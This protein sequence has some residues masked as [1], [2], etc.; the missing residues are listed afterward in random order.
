VAVNTIG[1]DVGLVAVVFVDAEGS[2]A[3]IDRVGDVAGTEAVGRQLGQARDR[4][5]DYGGREV[6]SL[7]DG[8]ML[9]FGSPRHAVGFALATQRAVAGSS[10]Q[11]RIGINTG[12]AIDNSTDP[13]GGAVNAAAR[14][15]GRAAGGEILVSDVVRQLVGLAPSIAFVDRGRQ[16][17]KG[18]ADRWHL[19]QAIDAHENSAAPSIASCQMS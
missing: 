11:I 6:K 18:F 7:G 4:I 19:W 1:G 8:L 12:E 14:I 5:D 2:T 13:I 16:R 15:A 3:L 10:P 17:L 9:T